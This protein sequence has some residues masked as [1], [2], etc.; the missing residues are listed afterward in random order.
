MGFFTQN[1]KLAQ[2]WISF[3]M[4]T[5]PCIVGFENVNAASESFWFQQGSGKVFAKT[6]NSY[7][8][9]GAVILKMRGGVFLL[10]PSLSSVQVGCE[11]SK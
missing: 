9:K 11:K 7:C 5:V 2:S 3:F 4:L 8:K 6:V 10:A 1:S